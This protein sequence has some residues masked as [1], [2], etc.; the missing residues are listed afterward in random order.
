[1]AGTAPPPRSMLTRRRA[2]AALVGLVLVCGCGSSQ[3]GLS[4]GD[5]AIKRDLLRGVDDIR[6]TQDRK[7]LAAQ[8]SRVIASLRSER[9]S[10]DA[11]ERART[12][13]L[14]G[15]VLTR[16]GV[17][18]QIAFIDND[19]GEVAAATRDARRAD[20]YLGRGADR[21]RRAGLA[22]GIHIGELDGY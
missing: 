4:S 9:G 21:I 11:G 20:R 12:A 7:R 6:S 1:M 15:F 18:S 3:S 13:A 16:K 8:L 5:A 10:T 17:G 2:A 14:G 22:L 19:R